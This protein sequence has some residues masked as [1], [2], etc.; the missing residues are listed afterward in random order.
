MST[1]WSELR[2][3]LITKARY[4]KI[5]PQEAE[6]EARA[7]GL[8]PFETQPDS[9]AFDPMAESRWPIAMAI[10]WI[11]WRDAQLVM[12]QGA[13]F[14]SLCSH[15]IFQEW[16]ESTQSG[17]SLTK[18]AGWFLEPWRSS[19]AVRLSMLDAVL[20][21]RGQLPASARLTP[22]Q[23]ERE[24][25]RA[26][27][28]E[29]LAAEGFDRD[30]E[31]IEIP[32]RQWT[33][34]KLFEECEQDALK[35]DA[36]DRDEAYTKVRFRQKDLVS[37]WPRYETIDIDSLDLGPIA[38]LHLGPMTSD[39]SHV[40][41]S[42]ALCWVTTQCGATTVLIRDEEAW[43]TGVSKLLPK[44][45]DGSIEIIGRGEDDVSN[46][47]PPVA[48]ASIA[49]PWPVGSLSSILAES[50]AHIDCHLFNGEE[51]WKKDG[52]DQFL[53][54]GS[55]RPGWTHLQVRRKHVLKF[56]P[57]PTS[58]TKSQ[59][60]CRRWLVA[61]MR[62]SPEERPKPKL[63]FQAEALKKFRPLSARQFQTAWDEA[64]KESAAAGW[65]QAGRPKKKSNHR[66]K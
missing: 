40:P 41:L 27:S 45:S 38:D 36:L 26:L 66:T 28:E 18:R 44:I 43:R 56:W 46:P 61:Q 12:E 15:W 64:I 9:A 54:K 32:A 14:R 42:V 53:K 19:T 52:N 58:K 39:A 10:A 22:S 13:E 31:L 5:T 17:Q 21:G 34:L 7:A 3:E 63:E 49:V 51:E 33:H 57:V 1:R 47:L 8:S 30:G 55:S 16:N 24:L 4:G 50:E 62:E 11:A 2:E 20:R 37:L 25:W 65:S 35:Y 60:D 48:F 23:A 6:A 29:R 59:V